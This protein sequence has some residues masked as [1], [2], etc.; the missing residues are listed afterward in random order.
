MRPGITIH[1][2]KFGTLNVAVYA[3]GEHVIPIPGNPVFDK[4]YVAAF[5]YPGTQEFTRVFASESDAAQGIEQI[6]HEL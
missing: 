4:H 3:P 2:P 5:W 1:T 6:K